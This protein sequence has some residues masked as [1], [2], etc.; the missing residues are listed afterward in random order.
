MRNAGISLDDFSQMFAVSDLSKLTPKQRRAKLA[1]SA[2]DADKRHD[3]SPAAAP[4]S[5]LFS[6]VVHQL[7]DGLDVTGG[8]TTSV[9]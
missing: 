3:P 9:G 7:Q 5:A 1:H 4:P 6:K 2:A 8:F